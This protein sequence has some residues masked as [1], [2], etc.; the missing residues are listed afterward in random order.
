MTSIDQKVFSRELYKYQGCVE[1]ERSNL[2]W[3]GINTEWKGVDNK[4][5]GTTLTSAHML[6][7]DLLSCMWLH[8]SGGQ[9]CCQEFQREVV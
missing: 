1:Q 3:S 8:I 2:E 6:C 7:L 4:S 5:G 9:N